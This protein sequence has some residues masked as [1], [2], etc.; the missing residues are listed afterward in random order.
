MLQQQP[1]KL[2]RT[3]RWWERMIGLL[4][5]RDLN[6][7]EAL[8][9]EPCCMIHTFGMRF[10]LAVHFLDRE[11]RIL[12]SFNHIRPWQVRHC[13]GA[14]SVIEMKAAPDDAAFEAQKARVQEALRDQARPQLL[15]N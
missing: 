2:V 12:S 5:Q 8:W 1:L 4:D 3:H 7:N 15:L 6:E 11:C 14:R 9:I 10:E 13:W